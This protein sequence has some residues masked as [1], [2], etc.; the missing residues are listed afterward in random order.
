MGG[1]WNGRAKTTICRCNGGC[2]LVCTMAGK[3]GKSD[4][5]VVVIGIIK[6]FKGVLLV[7]VAIGVVKLLHK[8]LAEEVNHWIQ[9]LNVDPNNHYL[10]RVLK[11]VDGLDAQKLELAIFGTLF[12]AALFLTEGT[13]LLLRKRW[14]EYFRV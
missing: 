2:G 12:Y 4:T 1:R 10:R 7:A 3:R 11:K 8:D 14:A 9:R 13:G 5:W 6:L